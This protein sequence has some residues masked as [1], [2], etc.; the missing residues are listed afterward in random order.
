MEMETQIC[1]KWEWGWEEYVKMGMATFSRVQKLTTVDLMR[2][3]S[4]KML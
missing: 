4:D 1:K 3:R 2:M